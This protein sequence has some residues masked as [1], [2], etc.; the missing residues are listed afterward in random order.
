MSESLFK[1]IGNVVKGVIPGT[2]D[3]IVID[4]VTSSGT[5]DESIVSKIG[6]GFFPGK[7]EASPFSSQPFFALRKA[8]QEQR[9]SGAKP[10]QRYTVQTQARYTR[11]M[12]E[13]I[14]AR[15]RSEIVQPEKSKQVT[16]VRTT[17]AAK[18]RIAT[19]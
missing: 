13:P 18:T 5:E 2:I 15:F 12:T 4:A 1:I 8:M 6:R 16:P 11:F 19:S 3:D 9:R 17:R 7:E 14:A 10:F